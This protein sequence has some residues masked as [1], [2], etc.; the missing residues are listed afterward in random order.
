VPL[1]NYTLTPRATI[2]ERVANSTFYYS[3]I[4]TVVKS[5]AREQRSHIVSIIDG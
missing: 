2:A 1:R 4:S 3:R 5:P